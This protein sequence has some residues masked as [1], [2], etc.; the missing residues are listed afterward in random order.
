MTMATQ[1]VSVWLGR[2]AGNL[3]ALSEARAG[4]PCHGAPERKHG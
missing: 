2:S 1:S 3:P 4:C